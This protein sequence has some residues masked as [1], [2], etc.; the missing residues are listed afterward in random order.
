M[1]D[2]TLDW[3]LLFGLI[4]ATVGYLWAVGPGRKRLGGPAAFPVGKAVAFL[5]GLLALGLSIMSPIG[6]WAD[7]Y[8]FTMHMVQHMILTMFCA[9]MLLI[10]IPEWLLRPLVQLPWVYRIV[11]FAVNPI[12]AFSAFNISFNGW[13]FPQFY[14][15]ALRN[16]LVHILEHQMMMGSAI[17]LWAPSLIPLPELRS[18]YPVQMLYYFVNSIIPTILG[19]LITFADSVLYPTYELAPRIWG[20]SAIADQQIGALIMWIPGGSI[21]ILAITIAFFKWMNREDEEQSLPS[22]AD[23]K[24]AARQ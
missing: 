21:F 24:A 12:V 1:N 4:A 20:I 17:L 14:D 22:I 16:E 10:G 23:Q 7:R 2:W 3:P 19:A 13:H 11:R 9:P 6:I 5:S 15:L 18:S 8:L